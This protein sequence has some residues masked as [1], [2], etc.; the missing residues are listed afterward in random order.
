MK[1]ELY[2]GS[3]ARSKQ[4]RLV[5]GVLLACAIGRAQSGD[6]YTEALALVKA[7]KPEL[8]M[9]L[10]EK[11]LGSAPRDLKAG[12]LL[13]IALLNAGRYD[14]AV[15]RF[16]KVLAIDSGFA[17]AL[18]NLGVAEIAR[19]K[20]DDAK[21]QFDHLLRLTPRDPVAHLY[22]GEIAFGKQN[23]REAAA[24][25]EQSGG[26]HLKQTDYTLH[27][28][29]SAFEMHNA[30]AAAKALESIPE[31][32]AAEIHF[33]TGVLF[34]SAG[35]YSE[36]GRH[37][38]LAQSGG[39]DPYEAG[40]NIV[41]TSF[42]GGDSAGAID[43]GKQMIAAGFRKAELYNLLARVYEQVGQTERAYDALR[44]AID[45]DPADENNYLDMMALAV[46]HENLPLSL[47]TSEVAVS[48][49]PAAYGAR[50][51]R[52]AVLALMGQPTDA[53]A[54]YLEAI[55]MQPE[56]NLGHIALAMVRI[57]SGKVAEAAAALRERRTKSPDDYLI[58][59]YLGE[60]LSR[61]G[62][63]EEAIPLLRAA[64]RANSSAAA[65]HALL[66]KLLAAGGELQQAAEE[67]EAALKLEPESRAPAYQLAM[68]YRK[69]GNSKRADAMLELYDKGKP[70][71]EGEAAARELLKRLQV[72]H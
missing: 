48:R 46:R 67:F 3:V 14:E 56:N 38:K 22:L 30:S 53:E 51:Q 63:N 17:P 15:A 69:L 45:Q 62:E 31:N 12:N 49:L 42:K 28:A 2:N 33:Q 21:V 20:P 68:V 70:A 23:Y 34:A 60:A 35:M 57:Q 13:G 27:F 44:T 61:Q 66:G 6:A 9:P 39:A 16:H 37:F 59:L 50:L 41:L 36:A 58:N 7:G 10:L 24:H 29:K 47:K 5:L 8:A 1:S 43:A 18:K 54:V 40:F 11:V 64:V 71:Q 26:L 25:Y 55:R 72:S 19:G 4:A 65:P 52:G 32:A